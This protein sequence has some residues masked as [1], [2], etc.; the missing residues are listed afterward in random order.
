MA[1]L[2]WTVDVLRKIDGVGD[3]QRTLS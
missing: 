3:A 2:W 1:E